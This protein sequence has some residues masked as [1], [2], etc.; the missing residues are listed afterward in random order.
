METKY[1]LTPPL[2]VIP[3]QGAAAFQE[4]NGGPRCAGYPFRLSRVDAGSFFSPRFF[5]NGKRRRFG[6]CT[7]SA[8]RLKAF[9][10]VVGGAK[11]AHELR[12]A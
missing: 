9:F 7:V 4:R 12:P 8:T 2:G 10:M 11:N 5:K 3:F 1:K 6:D